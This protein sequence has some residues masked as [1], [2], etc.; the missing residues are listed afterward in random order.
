MFSDNEVIFLNFDL[1]GYDI[2][3]I[4]W[5]LNNW[6]NPLINERFIDIYRAFFVEFCLH[7]YAY[8]D[9]FDELKKLKKGNPFYVWRRKFNWRKHTDLQIKNLK[10]FKSPDGGKHFYSSSMFSICSGKGADKTSPIEK[11]LIVKFIFTPEL[12]FSFQDIKYRAYICN[13]LKKYWEILS[14]FFEWIRKNKY[15][16]KVEKIDFDI[17][18]KTLTKDDAEELSKIFNLIKY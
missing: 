4:M 3:N 14:N 8:T 13:R 17:F 6:S 10:L 7:I 1:I 12:I 9:K 15:I 5:L 18:Y 11:E 16:F 2:R